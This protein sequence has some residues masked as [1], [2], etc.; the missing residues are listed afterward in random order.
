[1][2]AV[3]WSRAVHGTGDPEIDR[4]HREL[5]RHINLLLSAI[6]EGHG[7]PAI[8]NMLSFLHGYLTDH[9]AFEERLMA[10]RKS[11]AL[12]ENSRQHMH[13]L[14][15]YDE[16]HE[17]FA[18]EGATPAVMQRIEKVL[19]DWADG[20]IPDIDTGLRRPVHSRETP[21]LPSA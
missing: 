13:L 2:N 4:Q 10:A 18:R 11:P 14:G 7:A 20:H 6:E 3:E 15:Q 8:G 12:D 5:F 16:L 17:A 19:C 21:P 9:C 1:M